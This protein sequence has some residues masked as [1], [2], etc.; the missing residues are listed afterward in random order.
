MYVVSPRAT[1]EKISKIY[2]VK[3]SLK[4]YK[5]CPRKYSLNAEE[6]KKE[7]EKTKMT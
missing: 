3:K 2:V 4:G 5:H 1:T 7:I 6:S